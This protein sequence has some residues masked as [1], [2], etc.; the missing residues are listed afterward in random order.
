[1]SEEGKIQGFDYRAT[2]KDPRTGAVIKTQ[3]YIRHVSGTGGE[4][5]KRISGEDAGKFFNVK[6]EEIPDPKAAPV[7]D[8]AASLTSPVTDAANAKPKVSFT[9]RA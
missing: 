3:E 9:T 4:Y 6:G 7:A 2:I 5:L 8:S 1:V